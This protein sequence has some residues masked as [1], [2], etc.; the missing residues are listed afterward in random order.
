M[1]LPDNAAEDRSQ[2]RRLRV[3]SFVEA[4]TLLILMLVAVPLKHGLGYPLATRIVG[5][6]HGAAFVAYIWS[7]V[8]TVSGGE[9]RR[10]EVA[11]L[12]LAAF[13][14]FGGF[15]NAGMLRRKQA[16]LAAVPEERR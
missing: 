2:V 8:A 14:P 9:W 12:V 15:L 13:V 5:P 7:I 1:T 10:R 4:S 11:R 6:I 16:V 3:L